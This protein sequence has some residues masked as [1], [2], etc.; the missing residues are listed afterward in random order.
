MFKNETYEERKAR[1]SN[2]YEALLRQPNEVD[3]RW[4]NGVFL[5][6]RKPVVSAE[7]TPLEWRYDFDE[8]RNPFLMERMGMNAA[9][10]AGAI[11]HDGKIVLAV[12]LEGNDRKSFF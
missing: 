9:F 2:E 6:F 12:R 1:L 4:D 10:N 5:R 7:H 11:E 3:L 8:I